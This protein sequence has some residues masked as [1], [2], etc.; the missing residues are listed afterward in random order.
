WFF[1]AFHYLQAN[2][3]PQ[4]EALVTLWLA[5]ERKNHW[6]NPYKVSGFPADKTPA[7]LLLWKKNS[8]RPLSEVERSGLCS[9]DFIA[10]TWAWW[11]SLQPQWRSIDKE[12][13]PLPFSEFEGDMARLETHGKNG[14][15][16]LLVCVKWWGKGLQNTLFDDQESRI[17]DWLAIIADMQKMLQ[18]L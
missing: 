16:C 18:K 13:K 2:L 5:F 7:V 8:R 10:Q 14:W 11:A 15:L 3:G 17:N 6:R 1:D 4:Y 12:G 9:P